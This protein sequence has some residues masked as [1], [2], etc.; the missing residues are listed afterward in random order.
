MQEEYY[1]VPLQEF[2]EITQNAIRKGFG[3]VWNGDNI[4]PTFRAEQGV[5]FLPDTIKISPENR[6]RYIKNGTTQIEH[7]MHIVGIAKEI[8]E[9][10][11]PRI[12]RNKK[13]ITPTLTKTWFYIKNSWGEIS[14]F[15]GFLYMS[16]DFFKM[17]T[18]SIMLHKEAL[19]TELRK[20]LKI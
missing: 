1:N 15:H 10:N 7:V 14:K 17:K 19:P 6:Q 11:L 13:K 8:S 18:I 16:E 2:W 5:A 20:K 3:V 12:K 4:E 9:K